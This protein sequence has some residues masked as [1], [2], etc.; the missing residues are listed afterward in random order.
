MLQPCIWLQVITKVPSFRNNE[1]HAAKSTSCYLSWL[2]DREILVNKLTIKME[3]R[4]WEEQSDYHS[5]L[6]CVTTSLD[7]HCRR[8]N[9]DMFP[10]LHPCSPLRR[11]I[12]RDCWNVD[13]SNVILL[14][15]AVSTSNAARGA[16][17]LQLEIR[18]QLMSS[19]SS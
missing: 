3:E 15:P 18:M 19:S 11:L 16:V 12:L 1:V 14:F 8:L 7:L 17:F 13:M 10:E 5:A 4:N 6:A 9:D 2:Y